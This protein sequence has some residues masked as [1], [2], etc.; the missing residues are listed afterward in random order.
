[1]RKFPAGAD[2]LEIRSRL[3]WDFHYI[4]GLL[5]LLPLHRLELDDLSLSEGSEALALDRRVM[6]EEL[7]AGV[8]PDEPVSLG[9]VEPL[10]RA[11]VLQ[12][13]AP[14]FRLVRLEYGWDLRG[15]Y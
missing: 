15:A 4:R 9:L 13:Q 6:N 14:P 7:L 10:D 1:R 12:V 2:V 3:G 5:P 8:L 11:S